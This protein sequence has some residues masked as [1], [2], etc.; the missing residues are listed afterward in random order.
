MR[1]LADSY[2][3]NHNSRDTVSP[4]YLLFQKCTKLGKKYMLETSNT[5]DAALMTAMCIT[6]SPEGNAYKEGRV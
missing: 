2:I 6:A 4:I 1:Y 5:F 3:I